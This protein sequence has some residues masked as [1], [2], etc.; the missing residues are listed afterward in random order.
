MIQSTDA[1]IKHDQKN[2]PFNKNFLKKQAKALFDELQVCHFGQS[3]EQTPTLALF[4]GNRVQKKLISHQ[5]MQL[6]SGLCVHS[7]TKPGT[8]TQI[9][10]KRLR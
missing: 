8:G 10:G 7:D 1:H 3:D 5:I 9:G 6:F 4:N 2:V